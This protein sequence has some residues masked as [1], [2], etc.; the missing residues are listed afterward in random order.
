[1]FTIFEESIII[2]DQK[3]ESSADSGFGHSA[4]ILCSKKQYSLKSLHAQFELSGF[5]TIILHN[6][7]FKPKNIYKKKRSVS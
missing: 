7:G 1:M 4:I 5:P 6:Q 3:I 2:Y